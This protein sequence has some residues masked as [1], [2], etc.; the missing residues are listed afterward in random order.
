MK[1]F[2]ENLTHSVTDDDLLKLFEVWGKVRSLIIVNDEISGKPGGFVEMSSKQEALDTIKQIN[3]VNLFGKSLKLSVMREGIDRRDD[4][5]RR[6]F[7]DRRE[8]E[9]RRVASNRRIKSQGF[10]FNLRFNSERR[11]ELD[12]RQLISRRTSSDQRSGIDR[13]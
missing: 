2:V 10:S 3:G 9:N 11:A 7:Q 13:R 6:S 8:S 4:A 5:D 1:I 12:R